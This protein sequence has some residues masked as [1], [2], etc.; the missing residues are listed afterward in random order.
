MKGFLVFALVV[1]FLLFV[2]VRDGPCPETWIPY[3]P[4]DITNRD[5]FVVDGIVLPPL[6]DVNHQS[7]DLSGAAVIRGPTHDVSPVQHHN[8]KIY[9]DFS[10][11]ISTDDGMELDMR[12][13]MAYFQPLLR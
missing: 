10:D 7:Y 3:A 6:I 5:S 2:G 4:L 13:L 12:T 11:N 1:I 8:T 9:A